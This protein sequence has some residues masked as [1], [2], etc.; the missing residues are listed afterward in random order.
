MMERLGLP[1]ANEL[2]TARDLLHQDAV[3]LQTAASL[4][5]GG[6]NATA[7]VS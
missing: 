1:V 7:N 3:G 4:A 5:Y 6:S 2:N